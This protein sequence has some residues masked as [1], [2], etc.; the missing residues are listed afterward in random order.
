[1]N[2]NEKVVLLSLI[3]KGR[4]EDGGYR[5]AG[6][7][8]KETKEVIYT[9]FFGA[10]L[11]RVLKKLGY[12]V[13]QWI[14]FG[15]RHSNWS[16]LISV[17]E[18][19]NKEEID[20]LVEWYMKV[21]EQEQKG[22]SD[23]MLGQWE[24]MLSD[25][26]PG[27][28]L[29]SVDPLDYGVY[30]NTLLKEFTDERCKVVLDITHAYRHMPVILAFSMMVLKYIKNIS[31]VSV[32]YG[33]LDMGRFMDDIPVNSVP[34]LKIDLISD[35]VSTVESLATFNNSG[36]FVDLLNLL[37]IENTEK[38]YFW[39]ETNRQPRSQLTQITERLQ[40]LSEGNDYKALIAGYLNDQLKPLLS[41]T[42]DKRMVE[43]AK[44]FFGKKQYLKALILLYEG[45]VIGI[46]RKNGFNGYL[47][48]DDREKI[49]QFIKNNDNT[50]FN[51]IQRETYYKL[52]YTRNAAVHGSRARGTQD[53]VE[54]P[55]SFE[56]L[57]KEAVKL[58]EDINADQR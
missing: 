13:V 18:D 50:L 25:R 37:G 14:I 1:M 17:L 21:Y 12:N 22:I 41:S 44:L 52:E 34:V 4:I 23:E 33:A 38:T 47:G 35:L 20:D 54:Q 16:E 51:D 57:F 24:T 15:T 30:I 19:E 32:Y 43:R 48:Y 5:K 45:I 49:R 46:G 39:L 3:G 53:T 36:Y 11:Y 55:D 27:I 26:I 58:Y 40:N 2:T 10:A 29:L 7:Y 42:L 6:Y 31:N 56:R 8:F 28:R 9:S